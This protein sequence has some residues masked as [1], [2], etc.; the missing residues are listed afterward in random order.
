[1]SRDYPQPLSAAVSSVMR[2]NTRV[3]TKPEIALRSALHRR[4]LRFRKDLRV[5]VS[6]RAVRPDVVFT[7]RKVAVFADGCFWHSC[8]EHGRVPSGNNPA[9]WAEKLE[10]NKARDR[11]DSDALEAQGWAVVRVWEHENPNIAADQVQRLVVLR[12]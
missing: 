12:G 7:R 10:R 3:D 6:D 8:P 2:G 9:Y 4:G 11:L 1:V 5:V